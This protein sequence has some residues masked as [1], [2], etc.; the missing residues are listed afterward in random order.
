MRLVLG[1][2][3]GGE[4]KGGS[5]SNQ[6]VEPTTKKKKSRTETKEDKYNDKR[7]TCTTR[8]DRNFD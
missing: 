6:D 8:R 1:A 7:K 2:D 4:R 5:V 3:S